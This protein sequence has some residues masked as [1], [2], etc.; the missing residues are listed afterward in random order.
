MICVRL[1]DS[2]RGVEVWAGGH[3]GF[4]APGADI[5]C[6][7]VSALLYGCLSYL[8]GQSGKQTDGLARVDL[9][10]GEG[11]LWFRTRYFCGG[12]DRA[13]RA[14][15]AAGL[16]LIAEAYPLHMKLIE[17]RTETGKEEENG[18]ESRH[19]SRGK[20][21]GEDGRGGGGV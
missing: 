19:G 14:Q 20:G 5:V 17:I 15:L 11:Y 4:A 8:R 7:G 12:A 9:A 16:R 3:A 2:P 10:E 6:A 13:A 18:R 1:I 21:R